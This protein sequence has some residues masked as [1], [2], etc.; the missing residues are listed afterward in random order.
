MNDTDIAKKARGL[1][2]SKGKAVDREVFCFL[3]ELGYGANITELEKKIAEKIAEGVIEQMSKNNMT[4]LE[5]QAIKAFPEWPEKGW[6]T[7]DKNSH[8]IGLCLQSYEEDNQYEEGEFYQVGAKCNLDYWQI[9]LTRERHESLINEL[10]K[11]APSDAERKANERKK[12][13]ERI[14][15]DSM[16]EHEDGQS[17]KMLDEPTAEKIIDSGW[18]LPQEDTR[19]IEERANEMYELVKDAHDLYSAC[20]I[21][22]K[23]GWSKK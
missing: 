5:L 11:G 17:V 22:V 7:E 13:I 18:I 15:E 2:D 1:I 14:I 12:L 6:G 19:S 23:N 21:L 3:A 9:A 8:V 16:T 20:E 10:F 4:D